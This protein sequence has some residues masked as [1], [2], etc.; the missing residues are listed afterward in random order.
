MDDDA[1]AGVCTPPQ[2]CPN[3]NPHSS[4]PLNLDIAL[5]LALSLTLSLT[6]TTCWKVSRS[7]HN[8]DKAI[9]GVFFHHLVGLAWLG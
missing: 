5:Y 7:Q 4:A 6:L 2:T 8:G 1:C 9:R 3:A